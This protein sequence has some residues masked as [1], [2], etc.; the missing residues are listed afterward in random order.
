MTGLEKVLLH[1]DP[2]RAQA[3][4]DRAFADKPEAQEHMLKVAAFKAGLGPNPGMYQGPP[5]DFEK[6]A[7]ELDEE[8]PEWNSR[9]QY[10]WER[11]NKQRKAKGLPPLPHPLGEEYEEE[12]SGPSFNR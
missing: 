2:D 1:H 4:W 11:K 10:F 5:V 8:E 9:A 7:Q 6:A 3:I 12:S